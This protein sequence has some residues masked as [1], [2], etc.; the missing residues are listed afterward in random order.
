LER[1]AL[2]VLAAIISLAEFQAALVAIRQLPITILIH[3][4]VTY[5]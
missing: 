5:F 3:Q 1:A 4:S 2:A